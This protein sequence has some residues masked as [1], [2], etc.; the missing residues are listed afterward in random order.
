[1]A[2]TLRFL[3]RAL[4]RFGGEANPDKPLARNRLVCIDISVAAPGI[5]FLRNLRRPDFET[6]ETFDLTLAGYYSERAEESKAFTCTTKG[7]CFASLSM[8]K[9]ILWQ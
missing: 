7:R 5:G 4:L 6:W 8:T 1:M 9:L 2:P 3:C